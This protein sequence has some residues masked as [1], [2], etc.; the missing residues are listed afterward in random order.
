MDGLHVPSGKPPELASQL[1]SHI[2]LISRPIRCYVGSQ[3]VLALFFFCRM[4]HRCLCELN[5]LLYTGVLN[6][7]NVAPSGELHDN[8]ATGFKFNKC[9]RT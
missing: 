9:D 8:M 6:I 2:D 5:V 3:E 1:I 7:D 4:I